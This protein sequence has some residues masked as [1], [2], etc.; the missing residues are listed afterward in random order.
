MSSP[1]A[2]PVEGFHALYAGWIA[3]CLYAKGI[4]AM[5]IPTDDGACSDWLL[6]QLRAPDFAATSVILVVPPPDPDWRPAA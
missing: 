6:V 5:P 1:T 3:G 2:H 4:P